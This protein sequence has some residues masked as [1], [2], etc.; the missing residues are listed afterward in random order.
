MEGIESRA[1]ATLAIDAKADYLQGFFFAAPQSR[2]AEEIDGTA[3]LDGLLHAP[4]GPRL[5]A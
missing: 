5:A 4:S 3:L 1:A 2:L